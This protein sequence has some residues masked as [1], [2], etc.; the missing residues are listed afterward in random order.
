VGCENPSRGLRERETLGLEI[1]RPVHEAEQ[2][3]FLLGQETLK[4]TTYI[5]DILLSVEG[6]S[7]LGPRHSA[8]RYSKY[9]SCFVR[10]KS[11]RG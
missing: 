11:G 9:S 3:Q 1:L 6:R 4:A 2:V 10:T 5:V 7:D 8:V